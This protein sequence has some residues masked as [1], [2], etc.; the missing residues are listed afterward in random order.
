M[1]HG[2]DGT[3]GDRAPALGAQRRYARRT[4]EAVFDAI[5]NG[6]RGTLM[7]SSALPDGDIR[8]MIAYI[9]SLRATAADV[10]VAG[11][12]QKGEEIF[13]T[14]G[15]C[16]ECHMVR[17]RGG[18]LGPDLTNIAAERKLEELRSS[19]T[20][21]KEMLPPGYQGVDVTTKRGQTI[22]GVVK[23]ED[24][25]SLQILGSDEK[26]HLLLRD[27]VSEIRYLPESLMPSNLDRKLT[28]E[29]F[30]DLLAFLAKQVR[31]EAR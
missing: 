1:C 26:L 5:K 2:I 28:K 9:F 24:N 31:S 22:H 17:G 6:I 21:A 7:P 11:N 18:L 27:E 13:R 10:N 16:V 4:E 29:E 23:N 3:A 15:R 20:Q 8:K 19:L 12:L 14:K 30:Q 25:F